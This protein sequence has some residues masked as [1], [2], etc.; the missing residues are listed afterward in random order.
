MNMMINSIKNNYTSK[1]R[2]KI[3]V[4]EGCEFKIQIPFVPTAGYTWVL[5]Y[6]DKSFIKVKSAVQEESNRP[7]R[8]G[9]ERLMVFTFKARRRTKETP[10]MFELIFIPENKVYD[11][12]TFRIKIVPDLSCRSIPM[13][14]YNC[15]QYPIIPQCYFPCNYSCQF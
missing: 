12:D 14:N 4:D 7:G 3:K 15:C 2:E 8:A 10:I 5:K 9:E 13:F 11:S 6:Y 1:M